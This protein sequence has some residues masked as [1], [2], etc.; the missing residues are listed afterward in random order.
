MSRRPAGNTRLCALSMLLVLAGLAGCASPDGTS[1]DNDGG[2]LDDG[3]AALVDAGVGDGG[4]ADGG[5][6]ARDGGPSSDGGAD[7]GPALDGG[8]G[9][10][11][12]TLQLSPPGLGFDCIA[13]GCRQTKTVRL[14]GGGPGPVR[15]FA[16]QLDLAA[17]ADYTLAPS[18]PPPYDLGVG[19]GEDV[20]V[21][22]APSDAQ[23]DTG[24]VLIDYGSPTSTVRGRMRVELLARV[25]GTP[26]AQVSPASLSFGYVPMG[27]AGMLDLRITNAG[28]G[29]ALLE[30]PEVKV[31][32]GA[33]F[34]ITPTVPPLVVVGTGA[35][36]RFTV[37][38]VPTTRGV[39]TDKVLILTNDATQLRVEVPLRGTS[40]DGPSL[41]LDPTGP[42]AL[43]DVRVG[44]QKH[45]TFTISNQG[46]QPLTLASGAFSG[47]GAGMFQVSPDIST[48]API[49]PFE[50]AM[51]TVTYAPTA[52][53]VHDATFTLNTNDPMNAAVRVDL[54]AR[55]IDP[56]LQV[57][58][59]TVAYGNVVTS[60]VRG[61]TAVTARNTGF[62][63]LQI[64]RVFLAP[65]SSTEVTLD[66]L[67]GLPIT[68]NQTNT[69]AFNVRYTSATLSNV[70]STLVIESD[71]PRNARVEVPITARGV[72]CEEGCPMANA[73]PSCG[74][75]TCQIGVCASG[76]YDTDSTPGTGCECRIESPEIA[77]L[78]ADAKY[79]GS[80][81]DQGSS[82]SAYGQ[83]HKK[84]DV[85]WFNFYAPDTSGAGQLF[86][87]YYAVRI[88][89]SAPAGF[90]MC[91]F[92]VKR[93]SHETVCPGGADSACSGVTSY[94]DSGSYG[95]SDDSDYFIKVYNDG[96]PLCGTYTIS[97]RNG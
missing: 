46:G 82:G 85:D 87:D 31:L 25:I 95:S 14:V 5:N 17:S 76:Y 74:S 48:I 94:S 78:C 90:K 69:L 9:D 89:L 10:P 72:T 30:L 77:N 64:Q 7:A 73:T 47:A 68:L 97:F 40:V 41:V 36:K 88:T 6:A 92:R 23:P 32:A 26:L 63:P 8:F 51:V 70:T 38:Y 45:Q 65:G 58:P 66:Q 50:S 84:E 37:Q 2:L 4:P 59:T 34:R 35:E 62:G 15:I 49:S 18:R 86:G 75:G 27:M 20:G 96:A 56:R 39:H 60:W 44:S 81:D 55:G 93:G 80:F 28:S 79:L 53:G 54:T 13:P 1:G 83:L 22:Y 67:P 91:V 71:D 3:G 19:A 21:V 12:V 11:G 16:V 42:I 33:N 24:S 61:P 57:T 52:T 43:D 29:N